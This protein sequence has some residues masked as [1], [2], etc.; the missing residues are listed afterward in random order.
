MGGRAEL[1]ARLGSEAGDAIDA[2]LSA[3]HQSEKLD[4][5]SLVTFLDRFESADH[6]IKRDLDSDQ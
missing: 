2:F 3:A 5:P 6:T 4:T 1:V